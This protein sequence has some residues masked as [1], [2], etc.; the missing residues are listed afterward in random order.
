MASNINYSFTDG[1]NKDFISLC[2][3]L[4]RF[5]NQLVGGE[6]NRAGYIPYNYL[7][8]IHDVVLAYDGENP[9]GCASFKKYCGHTAEVK[10]VFVKE[11]YRGFGISKGLMKH[12]ENRALWKGYDTFVLESGEP[13]IA[14]MGLYRGLGYEVI[15]NYGPYVDMPESICMEKKL[16]SEY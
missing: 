10:R 5:L 15:P 12:L 6:E 7:D 13:L 4:D 8:D 3:E 11:G 2:K 9:V 16:R 14:A 1:T